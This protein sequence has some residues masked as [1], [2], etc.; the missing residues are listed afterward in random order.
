MVIKRLS[1]DASFIWF[2]GRGVP[3]P[4]PKHGLRRKRP[5]NIALPQGDPTPETLS[6]HPLP[7]IFLHRERRKVAIGQE[8]VKQGSIAE[9]GEPVLGVAGN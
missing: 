6:A 4:T 9:P 5:L 2:L 3:G 1:T 8:L 7:L